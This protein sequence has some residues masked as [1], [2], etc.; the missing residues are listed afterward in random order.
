MAR[1]PLKNTEQ[2]KEDSDKANAELKA[3]YDKEQKDEAKLLKLQATAESKQDLLNKLKALDE[4]KIELDS[5]SKALAAAYKVE[6]NVPDDIKDQKRLKTEKLDQISRLKNEAVRVETMGTSIASEDAEIKLALEDI[7]R[8]EKEAREH[9]NAKDSEKE[10]VAKENLEQAKNRWIKA[11]K[12]LQ[13]LGTK[14]AV[15][16]LEAGGVETMKTSIRGNLKS[17]QD[18]IDATRA[19]LAASS[20]RAAIDAVIGVDEKDKSLVRTEPLAASTADPK[21]EEE[22]A[23]VWTKISFHVGSK[24]DA[25]STKE[26]NISGAFNVEVGNWFAKVKASSSFS[27]SSKKLEKSMSDC[28]V[29]GSFS[30]ML[31]TIKRPWLHSDL[32]N[33]FDVDIPTGSKLSPGAEQI[34]KWVDFGDNKAGPIYRTDY[35]KF[36]AYPTAFI[37]AADTVLEVSC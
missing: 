37:V 29:D 22:S 5:I 11:N 10:K 30:A 15:L 25:S 18:E 36:P 6:P 8:Y 3:E 7:Y 32:F 17:L 26:S 20:P 28:S 23:D 27:S 2:A 21:T 24:S 31:V 16:E 9:H 4:A 34:K 13:S 12:S 14:G 19:Q 1:E 33:D 35:G